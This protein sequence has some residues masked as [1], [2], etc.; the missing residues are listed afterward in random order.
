M[1]TFNRAISSF[2]ATASS[3]RRCARGDRTRCGFG[4]VEA[5]GPLAE[6]A[7]CAEGAAA[8]WGEGALAVV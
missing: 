3:K 8:G 7:L 4:G 5:G 2:A 6:R 1:G